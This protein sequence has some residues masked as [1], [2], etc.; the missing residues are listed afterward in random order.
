MEVHAY[1]KKLIRKMLNNIGVC[2]RD[3]IKVENKCILYLRKRM[4]DGTWR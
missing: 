2:S 4:I 3:G 1:S